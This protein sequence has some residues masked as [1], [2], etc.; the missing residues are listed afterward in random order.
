MIIRITNRI[1]IIL[2]YQLTLSVSRLTYFREIAY[3]LTTGTSLNSSSIQ[4]LDVSA[5]TGSIDTL[6]VNTINTPLYGYSLVANGSQ[7]N[8]TANDSGRTFLLDIANSQSAIVWLPST[9]LM[10]GGWTCKIVNMNASGNGSNANLYISSSQSLIY[11]QAPSGRSTF[12]HINV[13][14]G[15]ITNTYTKYVNIVYDGSRFYAIP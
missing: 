5:F 14:G 11:G 15:T 4:S 10:T 13:N 7:L 8:T 12:A 9:S 2:F 6:T 3:P 1:T